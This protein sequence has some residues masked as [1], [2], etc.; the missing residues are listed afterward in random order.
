M[1][2]KI[3]S[4]Q[5]F[6]FKVREEAGV[7]DLLKVVLM[8]AI[9]GLGA[10]HFIKNDGLSGTQG[11]GVTFKNMSKTYENIESSY[12]S[13]LINK[14]EDNKEVSG[15]DTE[16]IVD[17][18]DKH[19]VFYIDYTGTLMAEEVKYLKAKIDA[20]IL[21][22]N[23]E[24]EVLLRI[25]SP[26]GAVSGYGLVASQINRL[27]THDIKVTAVVDTVAASGGY[28]AAVV[29][30]EIVSAPFAM[31]G[32]IGVVANVMIFEEL[33]KNVGV[34]S[35]VYTAG[36]SKRTVVPTRLPTPEEEAK[37]TEQLVSIH[38]SFKNHV[39]SYRPDIST[40]KVFT[41]E[42]FLAVDA[43]KY[44]LVDRIGTSDEELLN[45]YKEGHRLV[46]VEYQLNEDITSS[47]TKSISTAL[48]ETLR[49][50][51]SNNGVLFY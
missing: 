2:K 10:A 3:N 19:N 11:D 39:L 13:V 12:D 44:G 38:D 18:S 31:V 24:D 47:M 9:V 43:L 50:E 48:V 40:D 6:I 45:L 49:N 30:D 8:T 25:T 5:P 1:F 29:A 17:T 37:L 34:E 32:S 4:N 28:M 35:K 23:P 36:E 26:G 46:K 27:K 33:L 20:V 15:S 21:K 41:G 7:M 14:I 22:A 42:A 16:E 51:I